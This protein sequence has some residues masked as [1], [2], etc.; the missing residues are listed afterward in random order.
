[1][2]LPVRGPVPRGSDG[3]PLSSTSG[4]ARVR[5]PHR[6]SPGTR[7]AALVAGLLLAAAPAAP[8]GETWRVSVSSAGNE[9]GAASSNAAVSA[10]G[11]F[12]AFESLATN[13]VDGDSN[14][15]HDIF[16]HD[17]KTG[18]TTRVS[19]HSDGT[20]GNGPS[21]NPSISASGRFVAFTSN[22]SNL[23]DGDTNNAYD[24]FVHDRKTR[25]TTRVS[26]VSAALQS[27]ADSS[28]PSI[29]ANGRFVAFESPASDLVNGDSNGVYDAFV[30]DRKTGLTRRVSMDSDGTQANGNAFGPRLSGNG[31]FAAFSS[32]ATNLVQGDSNGAMDAFV[33]DLKTGTTSRVSTRSDGTQSNGASSPASLSASGR[34]VAFASS[35]SNLVEG[36]SNTTADIFV[37]DRK[38][39]ATTRVSVESDGAQANAT[40]FGGILSGNGRFV[41]FDSIASNLVS[42]DTNGASDAFVHDRK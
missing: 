42:S 14:G 8:A 34:F 18:T 13:L 39:G 6:H 31:R 35:G 24:V 16:V 11:R 7:C 15:V 20:Q 17:R 10:N 32:T 27:N 22:A 40:S 1:M 9:G 12:V 5:D 38:T 25:G 36:D 2:R 30:H 19:V 21:F 23:V 26:T 29:S 41:A 37:H 28:A 4:A 33:H 3:I